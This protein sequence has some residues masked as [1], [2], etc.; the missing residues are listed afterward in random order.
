MRT[1]DLVDCA[2]PSRG[3]QAAG[4]NPADTSHCTIVTGVVLPMATQKL[5]A[6]GVSFTAKALLGPL[7]LSFS[8]LFG[9]TRLGKEWTSVSYL[10]DVWPSMIWASQRNP[11][12]SR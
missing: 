6:Q 4:N 11:L 12:S 7:Q 10:P 2:R 9:G 1:P 3:Q 5:S 8:E